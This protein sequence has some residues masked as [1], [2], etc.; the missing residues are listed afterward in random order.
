MDDECRA[1]ICAGDAVHSCCVCGLRTG[2]DVLEEVRRIGRE[3]RETGLDEPASAGSKVQRAGTYLGSRARAQGESHR[4]TQ[5]DTRTT[6]L[7]CRH[8]D[9]N[10]ITCL[11]GVAKVSLSLAC[12]T[13]LTHGYQPYLCTLQA[14][15]R[16]LAL[17]RSE[18][19]RVDKM[20]DR[21]MDPLATAYCVLCNMYRRLGLRVFKGLIGC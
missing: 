20:I 21:P 9:G 17:W 11:R 19:G 3:V 5:T 16:T 6:R 7:G 2:L 4:Q 14:L 18:I 8:G 10:G 1:L 15:T 13:A 12:K